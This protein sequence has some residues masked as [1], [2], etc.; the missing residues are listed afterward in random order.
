MTLYAVSRSCAYFPRFDFVPFLFWRGNGWVLWTKMQTAVHAKFHPNLKTQNYIQTEK[1]HRSHSEYG[2]LPYR[3]SIFWTEF[4]Q[5]FICDCQLYFLC[6]RTSFTCQVK[7]LIT[8][9]PWFL[10]LWSF[11]SFIS[12]A[13][14]SIIL[15]SDITVNSEPQTERNGTNDFHVQTRHILRLLLL[16]ALWNPYGVIKEGFSPAF[17]ISNLMHTIGK[18]QLIDSV[19]R[20]LLEPIGGFTISSLN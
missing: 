16:W 12:S 10:P 19:D 6:V 5:I 1:I 3:A 4:T 13:A 8:F 18:A 17:L 2:C 11:V 14:F 20:S 9:C 15:R 7:I